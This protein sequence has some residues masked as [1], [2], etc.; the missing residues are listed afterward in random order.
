MIKALREEPEIRLQ[1][2]ILD[3][4]PG[5]PADRHLLFGAQQ[6]VIDLV[7]QRIK[8]QLLGKALLKGALALLLQPTDEASLFAE[9]PR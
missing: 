3:A 6:Q 4:N 8:G 1:T 9:L 7:G 2:A 5:L